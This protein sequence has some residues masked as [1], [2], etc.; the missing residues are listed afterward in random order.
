MINTILRYFTPFIISVIDFI[1]GVLLYLQYVQDI[2]IDGRI[3]KLMSI[4]GGSS[5][6]VIAYILATS[7]YMC[8]YYKASYWILMFMHFISFVYIYI[9]I[10]I[11]EYVYALT[12]L[13]MIS[14]VMA[15]ASILCSKTIK[16]IRQSYRRV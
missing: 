13:S 10:T 8:K 1:N 9:E 16:V 12:V 15:T 7:R 11:V 2:D 3:Y 4:T 5:M 6:I 14:A